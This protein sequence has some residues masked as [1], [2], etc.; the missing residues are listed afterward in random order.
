MIGAEEIADRVIEV[1]VAEDARRRDEQAVRGVDGLSELELH[2]VLAEG[3]RGG[4]WTVWEERP[5]P[6]SS[7]PLPLTPARERCDL[8]ISAEAGELRDPVAEDREDAAAVGT[9]FAEQIAGA[10]DAE[11]AGWLGPADVTWL[12]VKVTGQYRLRDG[13]A[14]ANRGCGTELVLGPRADALK[15]SRDGQIA[16]GVV[17]S[18]LFAETAEAARELLT[19][20][21]HRLLDGDTPIGSPA[22]EVASIQER[23]GNTAA[24]VLAMRVYPGG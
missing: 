19:E 22:I 10:R 7:V 21:V 5:Y 18:L 11:T 12:E 3:L 16:F 2:A 8:V 23:M 1:L 14:A 4:G 24:G 20:S 15:L 9:L 6:S 17:V 13:V